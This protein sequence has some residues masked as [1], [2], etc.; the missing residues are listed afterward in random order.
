[1]KKLIT[2]TFALLISSWSFAQKNEVK[3]LEKAVKKEDYQ[4][5]KAAVGPADKLVGN[6]DDKTKAKFYYLKGQALYAKGQSTDEEVTEAIASLE[7]LKELETSTNKIKYTPD[8]E[9]LKTEILGSVARAAYDAAKSRDNKLA[10]KKFNQAYKLSPKDTIYLY[11]AASSYLNAQ[12]Y[13]T[14]LDLYEQLRAMNYK[15]EG[16]K[17]YATNNEKGV[18]EEFQDKKLRD[19]AVKSKQYSNPRQEKIKPKSAEIIRM[20]ALIYSTKNESDKA[21]E[22]VGQARKLNPNDTQL[23][24][25]EAKAYLASGQNEKIKP[26]LESASDLIKNDAQM[27]TNFGIFA[28]EIKENDMAKTY[29]NDAL[30]IDPNASAP[31]LNLGAVILDADADLVEEMNSLGNSSADNKRYDELRAKRVEMYKE[32]IPYIEKA[33]ELE[34]TVETAKYL[35]SVY[36]VAGE[37]DKFKALKQRVADME[38]GN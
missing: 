2:I 9:K 25:V 37:T 30:A 38:A 17:Y 15:G 20:M 16:V 10:G 1:M 11:A 3:A 35:M 31:N 8:G 7:A 21:L 23:V 28:M 14:A 13:D 24:I 12:D 26:L 27:L 19:V 36:S 29:F 34:P 18:E 5:A 32:A 33:L 4:A 22:L 6:M